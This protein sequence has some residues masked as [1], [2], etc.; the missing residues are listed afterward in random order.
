MERYTHAEVCELSACTALLPMAIPTRRFA[1]A[2]HCITTIDKAV[3][4]MPTAETSGS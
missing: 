3:S 1:R 2:S 4:T